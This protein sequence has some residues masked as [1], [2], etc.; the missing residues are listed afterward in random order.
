MVIWLNVRRNLSVDCPFVEHSAKNFEGRRFD[1]TSTR[2]SH[3]VT[4]DHFSMKK[5]LYGFSLVPWH[6]WLPE[7]DEPDT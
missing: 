6:L 7:G 4:T 2:L 3:F 1:T 5:M